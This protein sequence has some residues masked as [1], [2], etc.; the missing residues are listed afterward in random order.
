MTNLMKPLAIAG[1]SIAM[2]MPAKAEESLAQ[3]SIFE[4]VKDTPACWPAYSDNCF[5]LKQGERVVFGGGVQITERPDGRR[6]GLYCLRSPGM[7]RCGFA[8]LTAIE[9]NGQRGPVLAMSSKK[10]EER[11]NGGP[12]TADEYPL[13]TDLALPTP[14]KAGELPTCRSDETKKTLARV[15][16]SNMILEIKDYANGNAAEKRWCYAYFSSPVLPN[17]GYRMGSPFQEAI[18][19]LEW[20]NKSESRFWL[21]IVQQQ[22]N[23]KC[24]FRGHPAAAC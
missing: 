21:Q 18:F 5:M 17:G 3:Y 4:V 22:V 9:V 1:M 7:R 23:R 16:R 15:I 24:P 8:D 6:Q 19:T 14:A 10:E 2:L 11:A 20:M 12:F 13:T